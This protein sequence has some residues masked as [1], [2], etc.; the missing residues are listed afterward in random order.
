VSFFRLGKS[1]TVPIRWASDG[2]DGMWQ[3]DDS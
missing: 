1:I 3:A 2:G